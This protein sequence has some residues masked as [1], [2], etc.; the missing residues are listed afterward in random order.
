MQHFES[1]SVN[2]F[3][4]LHSVELPLKPLNVIIGA[5]G[6]GKT[7]LLEVFSLLASSAT[8]ELA[9]AIA[10]MGGINANLSNFHAVAKRDLAEF[11]LKRSVPEQNALEYHITLVPKGVSTSIGHETLQ[12]DRGQANPFYHVTCSPG[13]VV[14]FDPFQ[15][16]L[17]RPT[18]EYNP[19][20]SALSQ[21]PKMFPDPEEF[22]RQLASSTHYHVL[23]VRWSAPVRMPQPLRS[24]TLPGKDGENLVSCLYSIRETDPDCFETIQDTL[25]AGF[26]SFERLNFPPVAAGTLAMTWKEK[27]SSTP[28][29][30]HQLSEGTLRFLWLVTLLHSP[31]LTTVTMIDEPEVSLHPELLSLLADLFREASTR[32]QLIIATHADRLVR[33]L[34]PEEVVTTTVEEDGTATFARGDSFELD[35]WLQDYSLDQLWQM[36]RMGGRT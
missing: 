6:S 20:E 1:I 19:T 32:T 7:S 8:G 17:V 14:Y 24:A 13:N 16:G 34:R 11:R 28:F 23:D 25:R 15:R 26:P 21:V 22:R 10:D 33:F 3:R 29:Y 35:D 27:T 9:E 30:M 36:G 18:W 2:G 12:Q 4:R 31:G 5:N